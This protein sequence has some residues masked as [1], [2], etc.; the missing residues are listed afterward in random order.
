MHHERDGWSF[1]AMFSNT[2]RAH[3]LDRTHDWVVIYYERDHDGHEHQC[4][5]VTET[6][7]LDTGE[8]VVRGRERACRTL[9]ARRPRRRMR[10]SVPTFD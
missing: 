4:T 6:R 5:V 3:Q 2:P 10:F 8:R 7:G 9:Y 1:T